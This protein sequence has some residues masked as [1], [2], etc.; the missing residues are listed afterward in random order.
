MGIQSEHQ[1]Y[2]Y[3]HLCTL[4]GS[5]LLYP[6]LLC[7]G[8]ASVGRIFHDLWGEPEKGGAPQT[9]SCFG[10]GEALQLLWRR[11]HILVRMLRTQGSQPGS[12]FP[13][14]AEVNTGGTWLVEERAAGARDLRLAWMCCTA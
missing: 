2:V 13:S 9:S 5:F 11:L 6:Q 10:E 12:R 7:Q 1:Q 14:V 4:E 3:V 8:W